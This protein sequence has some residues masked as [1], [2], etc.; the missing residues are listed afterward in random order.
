MERKEDF[1][2]SEGITSAGEWGSCAIRDAARPSP[3]PL[4]VPS[5]RQPPCRGLRRPPG[6]VVAPRSRHG[7]MHGGIGRAGRALAGPGVVA[8]T[9]AGWP[10]GASRA[11]WLPRAANW[12]APGARNAS[13]AG[14]RG[15]VCWLRR[16]ARPPRGR[17][18][19][20]PAPHAPPSAPP[21]APARRGRCLQPLH[22][23]PQHPDLLPGAG[24]APGPPWGGAAPLP[25]A[26]V[27]SCH[28]RRP[29]RPA[30]PRP[31][32]PP[33]PPL[34]RALPSCRALPTHHHSAAAGGARRAAAPCWLFC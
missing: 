6:A 17:L 32:P 25:A 7:T 34:P 19:R 28:G 13:L 23:M 30:L 12:P 33:P 29:G 9:T 1:V 26:A 2:P 31:A 27:K 24:R 20:L 18:L 21:A 16:G 14:A 22:R 11:R 4:R 10:L 3:A 15:S 5:S 8:V